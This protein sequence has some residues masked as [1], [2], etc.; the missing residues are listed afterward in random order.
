MAADAEPEAAVDEA[1]AAVV[2][3]V[4]AAVDPG[5]KLKVITWS[6]LSANTVCSRTPQRCGPASFPKVRLWLGA[7][8]KRSK[9]DRKNS[10]VR[11]NSR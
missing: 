11:K 6:T 1:G 3:V 5:G 9:N 4:V 10:S 2:A 7:P 8:N